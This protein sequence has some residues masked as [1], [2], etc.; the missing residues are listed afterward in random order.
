MGRTVD[1]M[2]GMYS[3]LKSEGQHVIR[4]VRG[5]ELVES[6]LKYCTT[7][8]VKAGWV[9]AIGACSKATISSYNFQTCEYDKKTFTEDLELV[10][11][12]GN[13]SVVDDKPS[14]H[15]HVSLSRRDM[16]VLGGH[17]H[18]MTISGTGEVF[19][20]PFETEFTRSHDKDTGLNLIDGEVF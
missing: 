20:T 18:S 19:I 10:S 16:S 15:A 5:E 13:I 14:L 4:V 12:I 9:Q 17:L 8:N 2:R 1:I 6:I 11:L 3:V 7:N